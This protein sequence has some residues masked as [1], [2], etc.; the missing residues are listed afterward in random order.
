MARADDI[1]FLKKYQKL[2]ESYYEFL[3]EV[4]EIG[5][6]VTTPDDERCALLAKKNGFDGTLFVHR[7]SN[8]SLVSELRQTRKRFE[9]VSLIIA[10]IGATPKGQSG[11][12]LTDE[13]LSVE[14]R[15]NA[16]QSDS[17]LKVD[18]RMTLMLNNNPLLEDLT[19]QQW[20]AR[21]GCSKQAVATTKT[22]KAIMYRRKSREDSLRGR[23]P[24]KRLRQPP[25]G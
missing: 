23:E 10:K 18:E 14:Q 7:I 20:G 12:K 13:K 5:D 9:T 21:L 8:N 6:R 11:S 2:Q 15:S 17:K 16:K 25:T 3:N 1:K 24:K 22:W 4:G 19:A